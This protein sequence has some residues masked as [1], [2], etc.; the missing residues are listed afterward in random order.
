VIPVFRASS[1]NDNERQNHPGIC[2]NGHCEIEERSFGCVRRR[3]RHARR[4]KPAPDSAPFLRQGKQDDGE[5]QKHPGI[6]PNGH[7]EIEE[8][9]LGCVP[10]AHK[11]REEKGAG[12]SLGMTTKDKAPT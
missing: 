11:P 7:C 3:A 1:G 6:C 12:T 8:R 9:F 5:R 4:K 10:P 2:P